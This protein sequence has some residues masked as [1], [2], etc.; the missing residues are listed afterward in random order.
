MAQEVAALNIDEV[1]LVDSYFWI[2]QFL[3]LVTKNDT[4]TSLTLTVS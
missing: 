4:Y 2:H 3:Q 1:S